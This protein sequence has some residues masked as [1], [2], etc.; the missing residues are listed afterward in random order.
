M[1][2]QKLQVSRGIDVMPN[3][4]VNIPNPSSMK[5]KS[6]ATSSTVVGVLEDD[7][8]N[9][10]TNGVEVGDIVWNNR[11]NASNVAKFFLGRV[12]AI[13]SSTV[14]DVEFITAIDPLKT[15][16]EISNT[17]EY[18]IY[19]P[20]SKE[21]CILYV[22]SG[23]SS[24]SLRVLTAGG[25]DVTFYGIAEGSFLPVQVVKVFDLGTTVSDIVAFW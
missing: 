1:A 15:D 5:L 20:D 16:F 6:N 14:L 19:P 25:D 18:R 24:Q 9:F 22:G 7:T 17:G 13:T 3:D 23:I 2:Y 8:Q 12:N 11:R 10:L 4:V 21:G